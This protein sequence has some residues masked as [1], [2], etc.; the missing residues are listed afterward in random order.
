MNGPSQ[1]VRL[2][3]AFRLTEPEVLIRRV[4]RAVVLQPVGTKDGW[5]EGYWDE[6]DR[7]TQGLGGFELPE[8][9]VPRP[10]RSR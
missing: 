9:P 6:L 10:I 8:D 4:G 5:P 2:P 1:A 7:L 3:K